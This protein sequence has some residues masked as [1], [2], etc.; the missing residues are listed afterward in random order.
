MTT[1]TAERTKPELVI[2]PRFNALIPGLTAEERDRLERSILK[3]GCINPILVWDE[4]GIV[5]DGHHRHAICTRHGVA[6]KVKRVSITDEATAKAWMIAHALGQRNLT[7]RDA[8][9]LR[10]KLYQ[11]QKTAG[12]GDQSARQTDG[13]IT[14]ERVAAQHG[15]SPRT[16]ERDGKLASH[17]DAIAERTGSTPR[18]VLAV[19]GNLSREDYEALMDVEVETLDDARS[20]A[21]SRHAERQ[22]ARKAPPPSDPNLPFIQVQIERTVTRTDPDTGELLVDYVVLRC[23]HRK[24]AKRRAPADRN[25][26]SAPC[27]EC[28]SGTRTPA[29][30]RRAEHELRQRIAQAVRSE[31]T[32][33]ALVELVKAALVLPTLRP[34]DARGASLIETI[35]RSASMAGL[36]A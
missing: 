35:D 16:V 33:D 26:K 20:W 2:E 7:P 8:A 31:D 17:V 28:G 11:A 19:S 10:G 12:H 18:D 30:R 5:L 6:F 4:T 22:A 14:A 29:E 21:E 27:Y 15:V 3:H 32:L 23:G 34:G 13:Q 25:R 1:A 36:A 24:Y 9:Y